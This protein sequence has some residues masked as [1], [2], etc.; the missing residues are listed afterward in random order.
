[1][2]VFKTIYFSK[3]AKKE[4]IN[5]KSLCVAVKEIQSGLVD[6]NLGGGIFKKRIPLR[7]K[8]KS[9]GARVI[10]TYQV[11]FNAFFIFGFSKSERDNISMDELTALK[12]LAKELNEY[13]II[14]IKRALD[15]GELLE[16]KHV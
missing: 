11:D 10:L 9:G 5:D 15:A 2:R 7:G 16:V 6:A 14:N 4:K 8:G 3:W 13:S 1:M 12:R